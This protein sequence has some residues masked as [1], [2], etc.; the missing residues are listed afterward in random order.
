MAVRK[1]KKKWYDMIQKGCEG[2]AAGEREKTSG[3]RVKWRRG[4]IGEGNEKERNS[5]VNKFYHIGTNFSLRVSKIIL[6]II[7]LSQLPLIT[8]C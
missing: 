7:S 3:E 2:G 4:I 1:A 8:V 5:W 6:G